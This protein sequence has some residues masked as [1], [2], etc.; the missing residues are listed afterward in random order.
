MVKFPFEPSEKVKAAFRRGTA[1]RETVALMTEALMR[2]A[3]DTTTDPWDVVRKEHPELNLVKGNIIYN[4]LHQHLDLK[5][6]KP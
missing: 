5:V 1:L 3:A 6:D 2:A 4:H